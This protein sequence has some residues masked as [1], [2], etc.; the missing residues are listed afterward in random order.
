MPT[1]IGLSRLVTDFTTFGYL[2]DVYVLKE[3]Q[4]KGFARWMME[5]L[6]ETLEG[7][8]DL[9]RMMLLTH[10]ESASRL[11]R[12]TLGALEWSESPSRGL[13]VMEKRGKAVKNPHES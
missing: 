13:L 10:N 5:C 9:R 2:T 12:T 7:W 6:N 11:Y 8:P 3:F 1:M 4:G